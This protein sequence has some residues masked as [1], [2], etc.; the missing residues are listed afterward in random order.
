MSSS[1]TNDVSTIGPLQLKILMVLWRQPAI[2]TVQ[3]VHNHLN[4]VADLATAMGT[5]KS[6]LAYT[7]YL[8]VM[9]NLVRRGF[10]SQT[11]GQRDRF[12][13]FKPLL[14]EQEYITKLLTHVNATVFGDD[15][16]AFMT[17]V[18]TF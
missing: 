3:S 5:S 8:T 6:R 10:L 4:E 1:F 15:R 13:T 7:T 11:K 17:A 12:H 16:K 9:R 2:K 18:A 14:T